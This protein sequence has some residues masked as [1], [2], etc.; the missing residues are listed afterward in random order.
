M[1][2]NRIEYVQLYRIL[3]IHDYQYRKKIDCT[4]EMLSEEDITVM[5]NFLHCMFERTLGVQNMH[6]IEIDYVN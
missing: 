5:Q 2:L 1:I 3:Q 6:T 4:E